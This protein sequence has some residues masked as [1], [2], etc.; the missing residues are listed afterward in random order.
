MEGTVFSIEEFSVYDGP[1]IRSTVFLKGCPLRCS[2]C[3]NPEGQSPSSQILK[4]PNGCISCGECEKHAVTK[5]GAKEYTLESIANCPRK[6]LR[7]CGTKYTPDALC[8]KLL[9]NE[10]ILCHGGGITFSGGEPFAQAE[11]LLCCLKKLKGR[12]HTAIQTSGYCPPKTFQEAAQLADYMLFDLKIMN[13][14]L[15]MEYTGVSNK[16]IHENYRWLARSGKDFVTRVPL[17]PTIT[18]TEENIVSIAQLL[19]ENGVD[20]A[21]L[22]PYNTMAGGKYKMV[23]RTYTPGFDEAQKP[24]PRTQIFDSFGIKTKIM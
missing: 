16:W 3:H 7:V 6:L 5:N 20:Y 23:G 2:W 9:Q 4:S 19:Q 14:T 21:E 12:L 24:N 17:I 13:D 1:G 22:L 10:S 11:F 18:D 8:A 15:H